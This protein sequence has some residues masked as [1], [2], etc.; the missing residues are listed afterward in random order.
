MRTKYER[1]LPYLVAANPVKYG[2]PMELTCAEALSATLYITGYKK[3]AIEVLSSF[4]W[5]KEF[6]KINLD[7]LDLYKKY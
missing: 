3:E 2:K 6:I 7:L 1:L 4:N 5:G